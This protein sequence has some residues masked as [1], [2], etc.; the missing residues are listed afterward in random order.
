MWTNRC[1]NK[2][3]D[4]FLCD[5]INILDYLAFLF[6]TDYK[7]RTTECHRS[8]ISTF[9]DQVDG[10]PA[11]QQSKV[12]TIV[13]GIFNNK[14]PHLR[15]MFV[16]SVESAIKYIKTN[17]TNNENLSGKN[18]TQKFVILMALT[19]ASRASSMLCLDVK[20]W[21]NQR[22]PTF[23]V[24]ISALMAGKGVKQQRNY[25]FISSRKIKN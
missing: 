9:H 17:W 13:S 21:L 10:K 1:K 4:A 20:V 3:V 16:W 11:G 15:Y 19:S 23:P 7:Y 6:E 22:M 24:F 12:C 18:L 14:P 8:A 25:I 2:Q 5:V